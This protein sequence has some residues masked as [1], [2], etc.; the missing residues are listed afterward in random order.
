MIDR[1]DAGVAVG[2]TATAEAAAVEIASA[3]GLQPDTAFPSTISGSE[4]RA[5]QEIGIGVI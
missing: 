3:A 1:N 4:P 2:V 5:S